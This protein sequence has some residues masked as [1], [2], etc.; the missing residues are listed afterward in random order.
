MY[1]KTELNKNSETAETTIVFLSGT[2]RF[3][4]FLCQHKEDVSLLEL[5]LSVS[6]YKADLSEGKE[7][8]SCTWGSLPKQIR[9]RAFLI[10]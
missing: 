5:P 3:K 2:L 10:A 9:A 7:A 1:P 4:G 6:W 8:A